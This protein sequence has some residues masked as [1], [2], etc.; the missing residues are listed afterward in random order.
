VDLQDPI[1]SLQAHIVFVKAEN[2]RDTAD[3]QA[4][5]VQQCQFVGHLQNFFGHNKPSLHKSL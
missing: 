3:A 4:L 5:A 2:L 1:A